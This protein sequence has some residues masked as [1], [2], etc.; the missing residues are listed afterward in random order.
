MEELLKRGALI[1][2]FDSLSSTAL[3]ISAENRDIKAA[4]LLLSGGANVNAC[5]LMT[6]L[7]AAAKS[8]H[9]KMVRF[10]F[11]KGVLVN[12]ETL[13]GET[14]LTNTVFETRMS[15]VKILIAHGADVHGSSRKS[16]LFKASRYGDSIIV[17]LLINNG[18]NPNPIVQHV[19]HAPILPIDR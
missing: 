8:G 16:A 18:A 5:H 15:I 14:P 2:V 12:L 11:G 9:E 1:D 4:Q 17:S 6:P 19:A 3:Y 10:W 7:C 13:S